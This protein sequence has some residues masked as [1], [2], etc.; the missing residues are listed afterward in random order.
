MNGRPV[1]KPEKSCSAVLAPG[2]TTAALG[3]GPRRRPS[4]HVG[5][6][7]LGEAGRVVAGVESEALAAGALVP[8]VRV[9]AD[10]EHF[11]RARSPISD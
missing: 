8:A 7:L 2:Q 6:L 10:L 1:L 3:T 5:G 9:G 11:S 4:C